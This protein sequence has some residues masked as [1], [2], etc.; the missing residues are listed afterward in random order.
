[1]TFTDPE[2]ARV[3]LT[4]QQTRTKGIEPIVLRFPF[5]DIDR[6]L[7]GGQVGGLAKLVTHKGKI[8]GAP[9]LGP[10]AGELIHEIVLAM[11][12]GAGIGAISATIH[13][14]PTLAQI[15]RR[16]VNTWYGMLGSVVRAH[17]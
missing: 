2:L 5:R 17:P 12:T 15:H 14:Y 13:A 6:A 8:L 16:T 7:T 11:K 1:V 3:E 9:I 4:E 10:H